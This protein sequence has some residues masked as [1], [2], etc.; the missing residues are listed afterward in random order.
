ML[1]HYPLFNFFKK[2]DPFTPTS[3]LNVLQTSYLNKAKLPL[4]EW[5]DP[6]DLKENGFLITNDE[7]EKFLF[8]MAFHDGERNEKISSKSSFNKKTPGPVLINQSKKT[9]YKIYR[10]Q[11]KEDNHDTIN[12][13]NPFGF[14]Q[15]PKR[16]LGK[17]GFGKVCICQNLITGEWYAVKIIKK[18]F[19][20]RLGESIGF[21]TFY[22]PNEIKF[23]KQQNLFIDCIE[24]K[25]KYYVIQKLIEGRDL[26]ALSEDDFHLLSD[27]PRKII[28]PFFELLKK[29]VITTAN[30]HQNGCIHRDISPDN[31]LYDQKE[32]RLYL[33]DFG[34]AIELKQGSNS[35]YRR[36]RCGKKPFM[37]PEIIEKGLYSY[38]SD[39]YALGICFKRLIHRLPS[40][41]QYQFKFVSKLER[42]A[43]EMSDPNSHLRPGLFTIHHSLNSIMAKAIKEEIDTLIIEP[44]SARFRLLKLSN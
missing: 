25:E 3:S 39:I 43:N 34:F 33:I 29:I 42:L 37:A 8:Y 11:I 23:L 14:S 30:F 44:I 32:N 17:G 2:N 10:P 5:I 18:S 22:Q 24:I 40:E 6:N 21:N 35:V 7:K 15:K 27:D 1:S 9:L 38:L 41:I 19:F 31:F 16:I 28:T 4:N 20:E 36:E 26:N 13:L 12:S